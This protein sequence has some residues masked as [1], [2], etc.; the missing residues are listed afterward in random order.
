MVSRGHA[1]CKAD[2]LKLEINLIKKF[3]SWNDLPKAIASVI[4]NRSLNTDDKTDQAN[5]SDPNTDTDVTTVYFRMSY[6]GDKG[7]SLIKA[8]INKIRANCIKN[9]KIVFKIKYYMM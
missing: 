6:F 7:V 2:K 4:I 3:V 5:D 8:C 9:R 1:I